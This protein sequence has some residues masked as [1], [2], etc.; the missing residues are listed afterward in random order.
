MKRDYFVSRLEI[1]LL[2]RFGY[3]ITRMT[4]DRQAVE[5]DLTEEERLFGERLKSTS[6]TTGLI[7][8]PEIDFLGH[9]I[10]EIS[11]E[12]LEVI[13]LKPQDVNYK[14]ITTARILRDKK[15]PLS[16]NEWRNDHLQWT[17]DDGIKHTGDISYVGWLGTWGEG[18]IAH[19]LAVRF[20]G[21]EIFVQ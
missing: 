6:E 12:E 11:R 7:Y 4:P 10:Y 14:V 2:Q 20:Y 5:A 16:L 1:R 15:L 18:Q 19:N 21:K 17:D 8:K 3:M 9:S 13:G